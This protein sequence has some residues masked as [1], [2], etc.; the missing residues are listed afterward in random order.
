MKKIWLLF[1]LSFFTFS[2]NSLAQKTFTSADVFTEK[3][4]VWYG[5][6]FT[7][8]RFIGQASIHGNFYKTP[9]YVVKNYFKEWN[10]IPLKES[11]K[12]D[13]KKSFEKEY[14]YYDVDTLIARNQ[15]FDSDSLISFSNIYTLNTTIFPST[16]KSYGGNAKEGIGVV[17]IVESFNSIEEVAT[18]YCVVFDIATKKILL[19]EKITGRPKGGSVKTYWAG[20]F[21]EALEKNHKVYSKWKKGAMIK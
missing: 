15:R 20:A 11:E 9:D 6:D 18:F 2:L 3:N 8:M 4:M 13:I 1:I 5:F 19:Q 10:M 12:Y 16:I 14:I 21:H 17:Y 7:Q